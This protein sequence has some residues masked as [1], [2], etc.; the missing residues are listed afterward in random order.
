LASNNEAGKSLR[1]RRFEG[2]VVFCIKTDGF[3]DKQLEP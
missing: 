2:F 3:L 1:I